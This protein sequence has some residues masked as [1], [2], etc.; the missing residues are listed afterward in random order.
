[1][2]ASSMTPHH[3][4]GRTNECEL[5]ID[6][7]SRVMSS[8]LATIAIVLARSFVAQ[9]HEFVRP[10]QS[11]DI[12]GRFLTTGWSHAEIVLAH[13]MH[14]PLLILVEDRVHIDGVLEAFQIAGRLHTFS[15]ARDENSLLE[16]LTLMFSSFRESLDLP[17]N[18][19]LQGKSE[20]R[21]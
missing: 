10:C 19:V 2:S 7:I 21:A 14:H 1:M 15:L 18:Q 20:G 13:Q 4:D 8:C 17:E 12:S 6:S 16:S 3:V 5:P 11:F 9:G